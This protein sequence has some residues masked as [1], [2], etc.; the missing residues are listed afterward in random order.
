[1]TA[2]MLDRERSGKLQ[3]VMTT[4]MLD[5]ERSGKLQYVMP[6]EKVDRKKDRGRPSGKILNGLKS[7]H[8]RTSASKMIGSTQNRIM[9][10]DM[11][12]NAIT[13]CR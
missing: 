12:T 9:W 1:M 11:M 7:W 13:I 8:G 5:Q 3:Y 2:E 10:T 4:E 6:A